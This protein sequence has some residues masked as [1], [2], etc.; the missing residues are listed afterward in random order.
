MRITPSLFSI[1]LVSALS[2]V[3]DYVVDE[4][5]GILPLGDTPLAGTT[6]GGNNNSIFPKFIFDNGPDLN[7]GTEVV[8]QFELAQP[9]ILSITSHSIVN[10][11]DF[12]LLNSLATSLDFQSGKI[13][14]DGALEAVLLQETPS[15]TEYFSPLLPGIY[16]LAVES[17]Y[18][19]DGNVLAQ[20]AEYDVDLTVEEGIS[21]DF[22][23]DLGPIAK[24]GT[25]LTFDTNGSAF[26]TE[27]AIYDY[28][29]G[30][31]LYENDNAPG[32]ELWSVIDLPGGLPDGTYYAVVAGN[33]ATFEPDWVLD[34]GDASGAWVFNYPL[35]PTFG[36]GVEMGE[37]DSAFVGTE[38]QWFIFDVKDA[39]S[40][41]IDLGKLAAPGVPFMIDTLG[42][43]FDTQL[44]LYDS[45]GF[46]I[47][48]SDDISDDNL[49]SRLDFTAGLSA[50]EYFLSLAGWPHIFF[51]G[52]ALRVDTAE[53]PFSDSGPYT[54]NH[55]GG[56]A[57]GTIAEDSSQWFSFT[58]A[59]SS[60]QITD[61]AFNPAT[62]EFT[63]S[64]TSSLPGPFNIFVGNGADL[65]ALQA[66]P[67]NVLP[68]QAAAGASSPAA[69]AV[70]VE[71][72]GPQVFFQVTD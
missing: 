44:A 40:N 9:S 50:G 48:F 30:E 59:S 43:E 1:L 14:A 61:V 18:G 47:D 42:S 37:T 70:P 55:P 4:N 11:P 32:G 7:F 68:I 19:T 45:E 10:D 41:V 28:F 54:L 56:P 17:Y 35:G 24:A 2:A 31:L 12:F 34:G 29:S 71:L 51:D 36:P 38:A 60:I 69:F 33:D 64:W 15:Q 53:F 72:R 67:N 3:A 8:Y 46:I 22:S 21:I 27:L 49:R 66:A 6:A 13:A 62:N 65:S 26:D 58:V 52:F 23:I 5:L 20:D 57:S 25:P 63:V 16:Y 39:P